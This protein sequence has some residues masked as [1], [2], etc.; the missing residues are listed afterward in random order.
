MK[1][2]LV[3]PAERMAATIRAQEDQGTRARTAGGFGSAFQGWGCIK[4]G[5]PARAAPCMQRAAGGAQGAGEPNRAAP[6]RLTASSAYL[7]RLR[8]TIKL[9]FRYTRMSMTDGEAGDLSSPI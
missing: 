6:A 8:L 7:Q 2:K 1:P 5:L 9:A 3:A 4:P